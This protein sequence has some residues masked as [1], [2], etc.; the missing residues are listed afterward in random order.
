M[1]DTAPL[2]SHSADYRNKIR[3]RL[4]RQHAFKQFLAICIGIN[5]LLTLIWFLT[6]PF[7]YFWPIWP[8]LGMSIPAVI[9]WWSAYGPPPREITEADIDAEI[10]RIR[11]NK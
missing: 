4:K 1:N 8:M 7:G 6:T 11:S 3:S 9:L 5:T 2:P 10:H